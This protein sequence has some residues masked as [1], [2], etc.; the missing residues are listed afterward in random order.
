MLKEPQIEEMIENSYTLVEIDCAKCNK[1]SKLFFPG[2]APVDKE[3]QEWL[4]DDKPNEL[5]S[6]GTE[7][8]S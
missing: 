3:I 2:R 8:H 5:L 4:N 6:T 7:E 1:S